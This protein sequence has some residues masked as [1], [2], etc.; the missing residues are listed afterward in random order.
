MKK[1]DNHK[2]AVAL[3]AGNL[4]AYQRQRY[5]A[6]SDGEVVQFT[7]EDF[8]NVDFD[9]FVMWIFVVPRQLLRLKTVIFAA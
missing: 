7:S 8:S 5:P 6:I 4:S 3:R 9:K 2:I 1:S